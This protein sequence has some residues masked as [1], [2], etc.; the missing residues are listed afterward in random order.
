MIKLLLPIVTD[1]DFL[2][3]TQGGCDDSSRHTLELI[4]SSNLPHIKPL[5]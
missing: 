1:C 5:N 4:E 3:N 2:G